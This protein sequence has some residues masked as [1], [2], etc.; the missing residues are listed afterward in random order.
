MRTP[1][2]WEDRS[3]VSTALL[4]FSAVYGAVAAHRRKSATPEKLSVPVI[5]VGNLVAGGAGKT[6]VALAL[7]VMLKHAGKRAHFL[8]R[9]YKGKLEGPVQVDPARHGVSE[10]GDEAL[11]LAEIL[12]TWVSKHRAAGAKAAIS[13]GAEVIIMDD[14]FQNMSLVKD[15]SLLVIDGHN[16]FGNGRILPAGPLREP[17]AEAMQRATLVVPSGRR[18]AF[19]AE[20]SAARK[21]GFSGASEAACQR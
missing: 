18:Q 5:C 2:F 9:G 21:A 16:G 14:G 6:P 20:R 11:L 3:I 4:P 15:V 19:R 8:T 10:V 1:L 13:A 7:G 12:P 17:V